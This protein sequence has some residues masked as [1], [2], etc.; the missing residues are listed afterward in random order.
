MIRPNMATML[1]FVATDAVVAPSLLP[2]LVREVAG[3]LRRVVSGHHLELEVP[4][5]MAP[6]H[7]DYVEVDQVLSNLIENAVRYTPRG[8]T[9]ANS[10]SSFSAW[11][12]ACSPCGSRFN[13]FPKP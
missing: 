5:E 9:V 3:R 1:G 12:S 4:D 13:G 6:V 2:S 7:F 10:R 11:R 8:G